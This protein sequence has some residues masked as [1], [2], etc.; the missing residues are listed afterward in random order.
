MYYIP[1]SYSNPY[2]ANMQ[3]PIYCPDYRSYSYQED[4]RQ[5]LEA[6]LKAVQREASVIN[7]YEQLINAAP[8][9][10]HKENI[11]LVLKRKKAHL[12]RFRELY[13]RLSGVQ[14]VYQTDH[15]PF[16]GYRNGLQKAYEAEIEGYEAFHQIC[17]LTQNP[18]IQDVFYW[19]LA[20][21]QEN[22]ARLGYL[23]EEFRVM[24]QGRKPYAVNIED[25][26]KENN[27][28]RTALWTG[29]HLQVTLMSIGVGEDIGL[30][31][32][33]HTDQFL[34][35]EE[36]QGLL[37]MGNRRDR[38]DFQQQVYDDYAI[39]IPAGKWH[40]VTNTGN[41]PLKLYSIYAPPEHP[42]GTVH[43]TKADALAA[44]EHRRFE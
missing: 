39:M 5:V 26:T 32:H 27:T 19:A 17:L 14:P 37:Q 38:L 16:H 44:E 35:I 22:A 7:L 20:G 25:V 3:M 40:N 1:N 24:D 8:N 18:H 33:P 41:V 34:R 13:T 30:E 31:I 9:S 11:H 2:Y 12:A 28:F 42:F 36:G 4:S 6:I 10:A 23:Y 21:K 15:I 29:E 43:K